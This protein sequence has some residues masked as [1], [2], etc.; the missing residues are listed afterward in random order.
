MS[1]FKNEDILL[2]SLLITDEAYFNLSRNVNKQ[3]CIFWAV[4]NPQIIQEKPLHNP[5][6]T[7]WMGI[8]SS[9]TIWP[10]FFEENGLTV[11]LNNEWYIATTENLRISELKKKRKFSLTWFQQDGATP[12]TTWARLFS[13]HGFCVQKL[14]D[15]LWC[16]HQYTVTPMVDGFVHLWFFFFGII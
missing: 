14:I 16:V 3:N 9:R 5:Y 11:G 6:V 4:K 10:Y 1:K 12:H 7:V 13:L 15:F 2:H 8:E